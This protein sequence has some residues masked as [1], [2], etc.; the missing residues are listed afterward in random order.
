MIHGCTDR[1]PRFPRIAKIRLGVMKAGNNG[2]HPED[3]DHFVLTDCPEVAEVYGQQPKELVAMFP[4]N[5]V[6]AIFP[7]RLEAWRS[8]RNTGPGGEQKP[9]LFCGGDGKTADRVWCG[10]AQRDSQ[11]WEALE[12]LAERDRPARGERFTMPCP[13]RNCHFYTRN[14]R[15]CKEV[16]RLNFVLPQVSW[17]GT[18]QIETSGLHGFGNLLDFIHWMRGIYGGEIAWQPFLLKRVPQTVHPP[19][20]RGAVIK[21]VLSAELPAEPPINLLLPPA[22]QRLIERRDIVADAPRD[23]LPAS[24]PDPLPDAEPDVPESAPVPAE[25][26]EP[27]LPDAE[28]VDR[29]FEPDDDRPL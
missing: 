29:W 27:P 24:T 20:G 6:E 19:G 7:T 9:T 5:D 16:G 15:A 2:D 1:P 14:P 3:C 28:P 25:P 17:R 12:D 8:S 11:G 18:Y 26:V 4:S 10:D 13:Y 21:Y 22:A 23:L